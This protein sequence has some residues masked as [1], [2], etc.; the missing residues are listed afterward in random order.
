MH[1]AVQGAFILLSFHR[2]FYLPNI[3]SLYTNHLKTFLQESEFQPHFVPVRANTTAVIF[4]S[5][6]LRVYLILSE[7][8]VEGGLSHS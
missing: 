5:E 6:G 1:R 4:Y 2:C 7:V 3:T 8:R